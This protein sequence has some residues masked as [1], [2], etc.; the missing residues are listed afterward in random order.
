[1]HTAFCSYH[2]STS[3]SG[4]SLTVQP[5]AIRQ[6]KRNL[7][8]AVRIIALAHIQNARQ[9][10]D[11]AQIEVIEAVFAARKRQN[12]R[13]HRRGFDK[14]GVVIS[15]RMRAVTAADQK[16]MPAPCRS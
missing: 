12:Q 5:N 15:A 16:D 7:D 10:A 1:M 11:F 4:R 9:A 6:C 3:V 2:E 8:G 13:I 14:L